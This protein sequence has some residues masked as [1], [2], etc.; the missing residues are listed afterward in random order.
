MQ[1]LCK[2][3][4]KL[5][6]RIHRLETNPE[7]GEDPNANLEKIHGDL[8]RGLT[9][10]EN[11]DWEGHIKVDLYASRDQPLVIRPKEQEY[12]SPI[13]V[14]IDEGPQPRFRVSLTPPNDPNGLERKE[15]T[16]DSVKEVIRVVNAYLAEIQ[17]EREISGPAAAPNK[18]SKKRPPTTDDAPVDEPDDDTDPTAK[19]QAV[20]EPHQKRRV[21][22]TVIKPTDQSAPE[23]PHHPAHLPGELPTGDVVA[24]QPSAGASQTVKSS[25]FKDLTIRNEEEY[26]AMSE[27]LAKM[28]RQL[29]EITSTKR[30]GDAHPPGK[31]GKPPGEMIEKGDFSRER[32]EEYTFESDG[33]ESSDDLPPEDRRKQVPAQF[34]DVIDL[35]KKMDVIRAKLLIFRQTKGN[36]IPELDEIRDETVD[37]ELPYFVA[38][39][40]TRDEQGDE[41]DEWGNPEAGDMLEHVLVEDEFNA[42]LFGQMRAQ[43]KDINKHIKLETTANGVVI[44]IINNITEIKKVQGVKLSDDQSIICLAVVGGPI[45]SDISEEPRRVT[46]VEAPMKYRDADKWKRM[47]KQYIDLQPLLDKTFDETWLIPD[48]PTSTNNNRESKV[49]KL[50]KSAKL[51][52][53]KFAGKWCADIENALRFKDTDEAVQKTQNKRGVKWAYMYCEQIQRMRNLT[54]SLGAAQ[55]YRTRCSGKCRIQNVA[56]ETEV[57]QEEV[58]VK[59]TK[60]DDDN[61]APDE[62][63]RHPNG[64]LERVDFEVGKIEKVTLCRDEKIEVPFIIISKTDLGR[65]HQGQ[66]L[67]IKSDAKPL[68]QW[69]KNRKIKMKVGKGKQLIPCQ[70]PDCKNAN[71]PNYVLNPDYTADEEESEEEQPPQEAAKQPPPE[72]AKQQPQEPAKQ[73]PQE[74]VEPPGKR[75]RDDNPQDTPQP[76]KAQKPEPPDKP[77]PAKTEDRPPPPSGGADADDSYY[78]TRTA[79]K[80]TLTIAKMMNSHLWVIDEMKFETQQIKIKMNGDRWLFIHVTNENI[81]CTEKTKDQPDRKFQYTHAQLDKLEEYMKPLLVT[82]PSSPDEF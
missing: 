75:P 46:P 39:Y 48:D 80:M 32:S 64:E 19:T 58:L 4:K 51:A 57:E 41:A 25:D 72:P 24:P 11:T 40:Y 42:T 44:P 20:N 62:A 28:E 45:V 56:F 10:S 1:D 36:A 26:I 59:R 66:K 9:T 17:C 38:D 16:Y 27:D 63:K 33:E 60:D 65:M 47:P 53:C 2:S 54:K 68:D 77:Q 82:P 3:L 81:L 29:A 78:T 52:M 74:P 23:H 55:F 34:S 69:N 35:M 21:T 8:V 67:Y 49:R 61:P 70:C 30:R 71:P 5:H 6:T 18:P 79:R 37:A 73:P 14:H 76:S 7:S 13:V 31:G 50:E 15:E 22:P 43:V 12:F